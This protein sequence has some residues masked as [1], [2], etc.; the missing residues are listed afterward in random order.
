MVMPRTFKS[1]IVPALVFVCFVIFAP[2]TAHAALALK[3]ENAEMS[4]GVLPKQT[5]V[6]TVTQSKV[7]PRA[8]SNTENGKVTAS[9]DLPKKYISAMKKEHARF[10]EAYATAEMGLRYFFKTG[11][12]A[13]RGKKPPTKEEIK[14]MR[15]VIKLQM[16][17]LASSARR[18]A[19]NIRLA[20]IAM[21]DMTP[22]EQAFFASALGQILGTPACAETRS[23]A[24]S[25][26]GFENAL[27]NTAVKSET[28]SLGIDNV[29]PSDYKTIGEKLKDSYDSFASSYT[30]NVLAT[31]A[32]LVTGT[33]L[34][35]AG[36]V[37]GAAMAGS[38]A[39]AVAATGCVVAIGS[40]ISGGFEFV[41]A[42]C[43]FIDAIEGKETNP[44]D[45]KPIDD[46]SKWT[47][48]PVT[49]VNPGKGKLEIITNILSGTKDFWTSWISSAEDPSAPG[50]KGA[51]DVKKGKESAGSGGG[52]GGGGGGGGGCGCN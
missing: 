24:A 8:Q 45:L 15:F 50:A 33:I 17:D 31:G 39:P 52:N 22:K 5:A 43:G 16:K 38:A 46:A 23:L 20:R 13:D 40:L 28:V 49:I 9:F 29:N 41:S 12:D 11:Y 30:A 42:T 19:S 4:A 48:L 37:G 32:K 47:S 36:F 25:M 1:S 26:A 3:Y 21:L 6:K 2:D 18:Y 35:V 7:Q 51:Q 44:N 14:A 10:C 34:S 27:S